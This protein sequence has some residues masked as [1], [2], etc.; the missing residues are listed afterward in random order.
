L[1]IHRLQAAAA[2]DSLEDLVL[3]LKLFT[4][5][6]AAAVKSGRPP[7]TTL[8]AKLAASLNRHERQCLDEIFSHA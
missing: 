2:R 7:H 3:K 5:G 1:R 4:L 8:P 6:G